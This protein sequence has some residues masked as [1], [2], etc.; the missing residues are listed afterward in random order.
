M[1]KIAEASSLTLAYILLIFAPAFGGTL[2]F[3]DNFSGSLSTN[4]QTG[5]NTALNSGGPTVA[6]DRGR[7][8]WTQGW[9]YI[10]TKQ[11]FSGNLRI[12]VDLERTSGSVQCKDFVIEL[13]QA[14]AATG[15][16]R[17]QYGSYALDSISVG[18]GPLTDSIGAGWRGICINDGGSYLT[19]M[20]TVTPHVGKGI[21]TYQD[22]NMILGFENYDAEKIE[23]PSIYVGDI[24]GSKIRIW[25]TSKFRYV[26]AV[27]VYD[28]SGGCPANMVD[29][30]LEGEDIILNVPSLCFYGE[31]FYGL[32]L[33]IWLKSDGTWEIR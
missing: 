33:K 31:M 18:E 25:G 19:E 1:K 17:L 9:D 29:V 12:E 10:E 8:T 11:T 28:L 7:V 5:T 32:D 20:P 26:D 24:G 27:R 16:L 6:I 4:W 30:Q 3:E 13:T 15:I 2:I 23:A 22:Q 21:I 14:P